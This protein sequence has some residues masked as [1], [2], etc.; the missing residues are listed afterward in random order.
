MHSLVYHYI[1]CEHSSMAKCL[2]EILVN[3]IKT[4]KESV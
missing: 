1:Y 3:G 4:V 2:V